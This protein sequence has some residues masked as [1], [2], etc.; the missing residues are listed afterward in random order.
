MAGV[1]AGAGRGRTHEQAHAAAALLG[2]QLDDEAILG[3]L[4]GSC[5]K[6]QRTVSN[7]DSNSNVHGPG[8][9]SLARRAAATLPRVPAQ[10]APG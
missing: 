1:K 8:P 9:V 10:G 7:S 3:A 4:V 6:D 2:L 5:S